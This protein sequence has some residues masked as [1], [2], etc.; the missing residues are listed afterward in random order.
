MRWNFKE[1]DVS[2]SSCNMQNVGLNRIDDYD[3]KQ[4]KQRI[5]DQFFGAHNWKIKNGYFS[6]KI[7]P[8]LYFI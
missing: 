3:K 7:I 2:K 1:I 5:E 8:N 4:N 6:R